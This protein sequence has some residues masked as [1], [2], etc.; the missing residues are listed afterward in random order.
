VWH[1]PGSRDASDEEW[2]SEFWNSTGSQE[3]QV[4]AD[5]DTTNMLE[6]MFYD[7]GGSKAME[8]WLHNTVAGT[9]IVADNIHDDCSTRSSAGD[10]EEVDH[11]ILEEEPLGDTIEQ[12]TPVGPCNFDVEIL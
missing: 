1:G 6:N 4:D 7:F 5:V 8:D 9:F 10:E 11:A 12:T 3:V 2:E